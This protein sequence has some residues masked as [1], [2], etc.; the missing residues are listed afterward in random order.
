MAGEVAKGTLGGAAS[1]ASAGMAFGP[2]GA[3]AGAL[4]GGISGFAQGKQA[5]KLDKQYKDAEKAINPFDPMSM[6]RLASLNQQER[7]FR[8]GTDASSAFAAQQARSIA[9]QTQNNLMK[10]GGPGLVGNVLRS[11]QALGG[12]IAGIGAQ[13]AG[14]ANQILQE[15]GGLMDNLSNRLYKRQQE[16]RNTAMSRAT[17][18]RQDINNQ[19]AGALASLPTMGM[20]LGGAAK[21][22]NPAATKG[23]GN[24]MKAAPGLAGATSIFQ[25]PAMRPPVTAPLGTGMSPVGN[26]PGNGFSFLP[27]AGQALQHNPFSY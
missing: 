24:S 23:I 17:A 20:N 14:G 12:T 13:A 18:A 11:Q 5:K 3:A 22:L 16:L 6:A 7:N 8:A 10:V 15:K 25:T 2:W 19:F 26:G 27:V 1:G 4:I 9:G 21:G